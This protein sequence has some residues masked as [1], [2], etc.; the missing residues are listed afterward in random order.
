M[1]TRLTFEQHAFGRPFHA[2]RVRFAPRA[3]DSDLHWH[4]DFYEL[5]CVVAGN[6]VQLLAD[7]GHDLVQG[8]VLFVRPDDRHAFRGSGP[9]GLEFLN[10]AFPASTWRGF[11]DL[12]G[13]AALRAW[14]Q[15]PGP[16]AFHVS[17]ETP[18][19]AAATSAFE[20]ALAQFHPAPSRFDLVRFWTELLPQVT[21]LRAPEVLPPEDERRPD[22]LAEAC[23]AMRREDNLR[24]GVERLRELCA[25]SAAH[26]SRTM[27]RHHG[28]TPTEY[29]TGLRVEHAA[30][31][32]ATTAEPV[33]A[34]AYRCGFASQSYFSRCF[35]RAHGMAPRAFR[36]RAQRAFVP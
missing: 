17:P 32:L 8:D 31:L 22:W 15:G 12:A 11:V 5:A 10:I 33:T 3:Q 19:Y 34:I 30:A 13:T 36:R 29:V 4:S 16:L 25:V 27:R 28:C 24:L 23:A 6:G 1:V 7:G 20:T 9:G 26:L 18:A 2:A 14:E 21:E 35:H